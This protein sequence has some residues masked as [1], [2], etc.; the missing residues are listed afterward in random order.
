MESLERLQ[1]L[2]AD[3]V[4]FAEK[5]LAAADR[6]VV[7]LEATLD[8]FRRLL[9]K[10]QPTDTDR[11]DYN[12]GKIN[13]TSEAGTAQFSVN[14]EFKHISTAFG[15]AVD[16]SEIEAAKILVKDY[17]DTVTPSLTFIAKVVADYQD[18]RDLLLQSLRLVFQNAED[19]DLE[20]A[21]RIEVFQRTVVD[22][23]QTQQGSDNSSAYITKCFTGLQALEERYTMVSNQL[24]T[25]QTVGQLAGPEYEAI[26][27]F[28]KGSL[29]KQHE[30]LSCVLAYLFRGGYSSQGDLH[31]LA[32]APQRWQRPDI[33]LVHYLPAFSAA[34]RQYGSLEVNSSFDSANTFNGTFGT[35]PKSDH[36]ATLLDPF[37]S[38]L[39][40][41]WTVEYGS[42]FAP[43]RE[44]EGEAKLCTDQLKYGLKEHGLKLLLAVC[45]SM[46]ASEWRHP[47]R[48]EMVNFLM[49][50][51]TDFSFS[52]EQTSDY[53]RTMMMQSIESFI[54]AF[55]AN[56]P[57]S[58][59]QLKHEEDDLRLEQ[60]AAMQAGGQPDPK[61][62]RA[63]P[64]HLEAF[65]VLISFAFEGRPD[66]AEQWWDDP[67]SNLYGFLQWASKRQTVPRVSAFCDMLCSIAEGP[68]GAASAHTFLLEDSVPSTLSRSRRIPS[69]NY[70]QMFAE[71]DL[72]ARKVHERT[73]TS[74][75][76][77]RKI[78]ETDMNESESPIMLSSYL[79]LIAHLCRHSATARDFVYNH[80]SIDISRML[81]LLSSGPVPSFLRASIFATLEAMVTDKDWQRAAA[82]WTK[83]DEWASNGNE[84]IKSTLAKTDTALQ[85]SMAAL[86][87]S[88]SSLTTSVDQYDAFVSL[89]RALMLPVFPKGIP[90]FPQE[91]G[92]SYRAPGVGPYV[93]FVCGQIFTKRLPELVD[94]SQAALCAFHCLDTIVVALESFDESQA[95]LYTRGLTTNASADIVLYFQRHP[96]ARFMQWV[97]STEMDKPLM[98]IFKTSQHVVASAS[99]SS[100]LVQSIQKTIDVLN[101]ALAEQA[102]YLDVVKPAL[103]DA[104]YDRVLSGQISVEEHILAHP[105]VIMELCQY[106]ASDHLSL[107]MKSLTLLQKLSG[108]AKLNN[109]FLSQKSYHD[110]SRRVIDFLGPNSSATLSTTSS[111]LAT[112]LQID[113]R[114]LESGFEAPGYL[115]KDGILSFLNACLETQPELANI[116]HMMLGCKRVGDRLIL[117]D[118]VNGALSLFDGLIALVRDYPHGDHTGFVSWLIHIK[119]AGIQAL[120]QLWSSP[121]SSEIALSQLRRYQLL[122][123]LIAGQEAVSEAT[124]WDGLPLF[125]SQFWH[126]RSADGLTELLDFR[127]ALYHYACKEI[128]D[129]SSNHLTSVLK[130]H[131]QTMLGSDMAGASLGHANLFDLA[132]FL[133]L[134]LSIAVDIPPSELFPSFDPSAYETGPTETRPSLYDISLLADALHREKDELL[135]RQS[136]TPSAAQVDPDHAEGEVSMITADL[137]ARN[138][139]S[140]ARQAW[141]GALRSYA[142]MVIA[143]IDCCPMEA[144]TK[145]SFILQ[146]LQLILPKLDSLVAMES[147]D[148]IELARIADSLLFALST[149]SKS[150]LTRNKNASDLAKIDRGHLKQERMDSIITEKL[151]QLF[152]ASAD[153]I[154][155][156]NGVAGQR[157]ILYSICLQYLN[158]ILTAGTSDNDTNRKARANSMDCVRSS[159]MRLINILSDDAD[160]GDTS[161]LNALN[162]L[163]MLSSLARSEKSSYVLDA[164]AKA[165]T[166]E[167]IIE[168]IKYIASDFQDT[169]PSRKSQPNPPPPPRQS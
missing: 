95:I 30:A 72:Y 134:D 148:T 127:A 147:E 46:S 167:I 68:D 166:L 116:A 17:S 138:R 91:L 56:M 66:A 48:Q 165:N 49:R 77:N 152:R 153:G 55:I 32:N 11:Q 169:E 28:Q 43:G 50:D 62:D 157:G 73:T 13:I 14:D 89:L 123:A 101:L 6:L 84:L 100:P 61:F 98:R 142:D 97:L 42:F 75:L 67:E 122:K 27:E 94:N 164:L 35:L 108:S 121:V 129:A 124:R 21:V 9:D 8:D 1:G 2:H 33:L 113:E 143:I 118:E 39:R 19:L 145:T 135:G 155:M 141:K 16:L 10:P 85:P 112:K 80:P 119:A 51:A 59:R 105:Q 37:R 107:A 70:A 102:T 82:M 52:G 58:I 29:F 40:I 88:L 15:T 76:A 4:A 31:K 133:E 57:D 86:T 47:A 139:I 18:G 125:D 93:D 99:S 151:F 131:L 126:N 144:S 162:L 36:A 106:A 154:L 109:H 79:R 7:E 12:A 160:D 115:F 120:R 54:E 146:I 34:F 103:K 45:S 111:L 63:L 71:L 5:Q 22:V 110:R 74:T 137:E 64:M 114:E 44:H 3:L 90:T 60:I 149:I 163:A 83:I 140:L 20:E 168:P 25:K 53:F 130:Q 26:L 159:N 38:V 23:L 161:R 65:L 41:W 78:L 104:A 156:S 158:R 150:D 81:L 24:Q 96:F 136:R 128:R 92:S 132:D 117:L 69:M 87:A